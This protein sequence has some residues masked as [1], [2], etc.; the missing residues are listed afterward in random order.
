MWKCCHIRDIAIN[1]LPVLSGNITYVLF[2]G[3]TYVVLRQRFVTYVML[4]VSYKYISLLFSKCMLDPV[5][6]TNIRMIDFK[7]SRNIEI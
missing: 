3:Y 5:V 7:P 1:M 4:P 6:Y 2:T